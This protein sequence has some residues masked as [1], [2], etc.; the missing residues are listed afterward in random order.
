[1]NTNKIN[2]L[3]LNFDIPLFPRQIK[4]FASQIIKNV[5]LNKSKFVSS[6]IDLNVFHNRDNNNSSI[7]R[8]P[9]IQYQIAN[10][11][12][13]IMG[14]NQGAAALQVLLDYRPQFVN[15]EGVNYP[16][17]LNEKIS[18]NSVLNLDKQLFSFRM[19]KWLPLN[20]DNYHKWQS[21]S[22]LIEKVE[23]LNKCLFGHIMFFLK[24]MDSTIDKN[25]LI[26]FLTNIDKKS[27][28][29]D[30]NVEKIAFDVTFDCNIN[31]PSLICLGQ[32]S[33]FGFGK[34]RPL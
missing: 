7:Y 14:I 27:K 24:N 31:L 32:S 34:I 20:S 26:V 1:M 15:I 5:D 8:Y 9:L 11:K 13:S 29:K 28:I 21:C 25:E 3:S 22:T 33:A 18:E 17:V 4:S 30:Y 19:F 23:L 16:F 12:A 2:I 10:R 6:G